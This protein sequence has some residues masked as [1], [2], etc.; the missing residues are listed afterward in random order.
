MAYVKAA[1]LAGILLTPAF[2]SMADMQRQTF[3]TGKWEGSFRLNYFDSGTIDGEQGSY[4]DIDSDYGFGFSLGYNYNENL[5]LNFT[6]DTVRQDYEALL[7]AD[8]PGE[9]DVL[10]RHKLD[11]VNTH[12]NAVYHVLDKAFTPYLQA[13][14]GWTYIDSNIA[15]DSGYIGCWWDPW[16][17]Y[18]CSEFVNTYS[19]TNFSYNFGAGV[20]WELNYDTFLRAG[21]HNTWIDLDS[22]DKY[23]VGAFILEIGTTF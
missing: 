8:E 2:S 12:F 20:R 16:W 21:Y 15:S 13:G 3:R 23:D 19:D 4:V 1:I 5:L 22:S 7:V 11:M 6:F 18:V 17:G 9:D 10:V 14:L